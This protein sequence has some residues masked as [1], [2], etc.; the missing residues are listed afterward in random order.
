[1]RRWI[2]CLSKDRASSATENCWDRGSNWRNY[3][4]RACA[5]DYFHVYYEG[6]TGVPQIHMLKPQSPRP[7]NVTIFGDRAFKGV[8]TRKWGALKQC[9]WRHRR[10][11]VDMTCTEGR[12][13]GARGWASASLGERPGVDPVLLALGRNQPC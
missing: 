3:H 6:L 2:S 1:M 9:D 11:V 7:Q 4:S 12:G 10:G 13:C 8:V 5:P